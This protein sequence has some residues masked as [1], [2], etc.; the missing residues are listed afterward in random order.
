[1]LSLNPIR[2]RLSLRQGAIAVMVGGL[3]SGALVSAQAQEHGGHGGHPP[4]IALDARYHHDH[5]YPRPGT[6]MP[7]PGGAVHVVFGGGHYYFHGGVWFRPSGPGF[8]VIAPPIGVVIPILPSAFVTLNI[9]GLPYYYANGTYYMTQPGQGYVVVA[10]PPGADA[11]LPVAP[12]PA[13]V[14]TTTEAPSQI[15]TYPRNGQNATQS[16]K[17]T[18]ECNQ[19]A[20]AQP[21]ASGNPANFQRAFAACMD[22]RGYT[23][24]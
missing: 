14:V 1:M 22:G 23:V 16:A 20:S 19:W 9:G 4:G 10:P 18:Q 17:D 3:L 24:R 11:A 7:L 15:F 5:Y 2:P 13:T 12:A 21:G 8:V 6:P